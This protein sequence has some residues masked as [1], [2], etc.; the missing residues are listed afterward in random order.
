MGPPTTFPNHSGL[1]SQE[2]SPYVKF[3][4]AVDISKHMVDIRNRSAEEQNVSPD[5]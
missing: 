1:K 5:E 2:L 4:V 3:I